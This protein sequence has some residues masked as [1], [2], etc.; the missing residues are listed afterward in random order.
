MWPNL[1]AERWAL[2]PNKSFNSL[3]ELAKKEKGSE[4][5]GTNSFAEG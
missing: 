5:G 3:V 2:G 4:G 1:A